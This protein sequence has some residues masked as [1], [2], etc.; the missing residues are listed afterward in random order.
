MHSR[1]QQFVDLPLEHVMTC[2]QNSFQKLYL[3][4]PI[5]VFPV[6]P[7]SVP[8]NHMWSGPKFKDHPAEGPGFLR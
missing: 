7:I 6:F 4:P 5:E 3:D 2:S 8:R 1:F